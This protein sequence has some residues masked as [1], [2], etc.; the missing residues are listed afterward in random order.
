MARFL[1]SERASALF[2]LGAAVLGLLLA[3]SAVGPDL[4]AAKEAHILGSELSL[5]HV[6]NDGLLTIF[7]FVVAIELAREFTIGE[8]SSLNRALLPALAA[9]GGIAVPAGM[10]LM[11]ISASGESSLNGGWPI[12]TATDIAFALGILALFGSAIPM[13]V[14]VFLLALAV[15]DDIIAI[16]IIA[17]FFTADVNLVLLGGAVAMMVI[18]ALVSRL[19]RP[20][21]ASLLPQW[22]IV[23]MLIVIG[24]LVWYLVYRSGVHATIAGVAL[25]LITPR[26]PAERVHRLLVPWSNVVVLPLFAF[27]AALVVIPR[28]GLTELSPAFWAI[29]LALPVGKFIGITCVGGVSGIFAARHGRATLPAADLIM[30]GSLGGIGLTIS[31]LMTELAF[32]S[33]RELVDQGTLAV[34]LGSGISVVVATVLVSARSRHYARQ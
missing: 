3:N 15:L 32:S 6:I 34:L 14:R 28:W 24:V 21:G 25:G 17:V 22:L 27:T 12:P 33:S 8:F 19:L 9:V 2:L 4:L 26:G 13:Q 5:G 29:T 11:I 20:H 1:R 30:I 31:L 7:F 23:L 10:Y 16:L 18:F